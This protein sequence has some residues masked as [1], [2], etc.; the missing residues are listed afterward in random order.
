M[1]T[2]IIFN[3]N[4]LADGKNYRE[5]DRLACKVITGE[6]ATS[7]LDLHYTCEVVRPD[8]TLTHNKIELPA[9][10]VGEVVQAATTLRN[11][12]N[13][14]LIFEIFLPDFEA[15]GLKLT[16]VVRHLPAKQEVEVNV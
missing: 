11:N 10:Q 14:D 6:I 5:E 4:R 3:S 13:K 15:S 2:H 1:R 9:L 12:S 8:L 7:Q 16:P